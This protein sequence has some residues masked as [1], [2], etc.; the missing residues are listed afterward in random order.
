M[1]TSIKEAS[2]TTGWDLPQ[3]QVRA[4]LVELEAQDREQ[5]QVEIPCT[6]YF[7]D[8]CYGR[9]VF[10]PKGTRLVGEIHLTEWITVVSRGHIQIVSEEGASVVDARERPRTFI[11]PAGV[12]RAGYALEDTWWTMFRATPLTTTEEIRAVHI[13]KDYSQLENHK[14]WLG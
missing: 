1:T 3:E 14:K 8:G 7:S 5:E 6:E 13:A 4:R 11:S 2:L 12:K 9:E 10:I